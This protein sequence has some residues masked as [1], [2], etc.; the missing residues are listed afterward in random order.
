MGT[1]RILFLKIQAQLIWGRF[2][3]NGVKLNSTW[4]H[5]HD[6]N[7]DFGLVLLPE[8]GGNSSLNDESFRVYRSKGEG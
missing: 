5:D 6:I 4:Y 8:I 3:Y 1:T 7:V 2:P